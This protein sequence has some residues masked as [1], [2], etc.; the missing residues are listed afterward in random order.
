VCDLSDAID[1]EAAHA[2]YYGEDEDVD[3]DVDEE[4]YI[5]NEDEDDEP[6][7]VSLDQR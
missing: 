2:C 7:D 1:D 6:P 4:D 5:A 3:S